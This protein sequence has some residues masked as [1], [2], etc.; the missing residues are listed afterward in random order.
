MPT[1]QQFLV[2]RINVSHKYRLYLRGT[3]ASFGSPLRKIKV[4]DAQAQPCVPRNILYLNPEIFQ[5]HIPTTTVACVVAYTDKTT[6]LANP[7]ESGNVNSMC[8]MHG[9]I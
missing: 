1:I 7:K 6:I 2:E 8:L 9:D 4:K 3:A 5:S